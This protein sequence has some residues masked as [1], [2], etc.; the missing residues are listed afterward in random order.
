M[1]KFKK[2]PPPSL[3][4]EDTEALRCLREERR[5]D[6][7]PGQDFW[8]F[9]YGS[10]MWHPGFPHLEVRVGRIYGFS[11]R[12]C[13]YSHIYRG[14]PE[15]PGLV[16]GLD[17]GGSCRGLAYRVPAGEGETVMD[18][19]YDREMA[20]AI[21]FPRWVPVRT[22]KGVVQAITF[23][24]DPSH[25][26]YTGQLSVVEVVQLILQGS[27]DRGTCY[28]YLLN[29]VQHLKALDLLDRRLARLLKEVETHRSRGQM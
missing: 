29:T 27:G 1:T 20:T 26:Q 14:T 22:E 6:L 18:Y 16:F 9:G 3:A 15:Q 19:L 8:V 23:V 13:I 5:L 2:A 10:L 24:V 4:N 11:R 12:F 25:W 17:S 7:P 21:Y 28:E